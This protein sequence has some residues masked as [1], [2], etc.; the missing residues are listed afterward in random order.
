M[1]ITC[2]DDCQWAGQWKCHSSEAVRS[3]SRT[4]Y[5]C[6]LGVL[7][8]AVLLRASQRYGSDDTYMLKANSACSCTSNCVC[9]VHSVHVYLIEDFNTYDGRLGQLQKYYP[10]ALMHSDMVDISLGRRKEVH[11]YTHFTELRYNCFF[12]FAEG[13]FELLRPSLRGM[14]STLPL[15]Y[16]RH[17]NSLWTH[18]GCW[19]T[20]PGW[21]WRLGRRPGPG[22]GRRVTAAGIG[23][24]VMQLLLF[25]LHLLLLNCFLVF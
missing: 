8:G 17:R 9:V 18:I 1:W 11:T 3:G 21:C 10:A 15:H 14:M 6:A 13:S 25:I 19:V 2:I 4:L 24:T 7:R 22:P 12:V 5:E 16:C 23:W 20:A